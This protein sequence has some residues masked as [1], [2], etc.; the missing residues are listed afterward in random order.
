MSLYM[1]MLHAHAHAHMC[2]CMHMCMHMY[3]HVNVH[4]HAHA[5]VHVDLRYTCNVFFLYGVVIIRLCI[6]CL[7]A[8][9][10]V[11]PAPA[12]AGSLSKNSQQGP[13]VRPTIDHPCS[14]PLAKSAQALVWFSLLRKRLT[15]W[16][17][18]YG[19]SVCL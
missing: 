14:D 5:H 10:A 11:S 3:V 19:L 15:M 16:S 9:L 1:H 18:M 7:G 4:A 8:S 12:A 13:T 2:M 17:G 6:L